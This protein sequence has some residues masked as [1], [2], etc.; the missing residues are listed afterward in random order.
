MSELLKVEKY[1]S[2]ATGSD[3]YYY[4]VVTIQMLVPLKFECIRFLFFFV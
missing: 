2:V 3:Y 4:H 1:S